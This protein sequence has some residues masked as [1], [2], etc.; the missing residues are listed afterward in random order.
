MAEGTLADYRFE[1][2]QKVALGVVVAAPGYP[3]DY[4]KGAPVEG[5]PLSAGPFHLFHASTTVGTGTPAPTL[6]GGGRSFTA[7]GLADTFEE[8][9]RRAYAGAGQVKFPG[10]WYRKDIGDKF[11][12]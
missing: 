11:I 7:V 2:S 6:T 9:K 10:A 8:A 1:L 4:P 3:G 5:L 12:R